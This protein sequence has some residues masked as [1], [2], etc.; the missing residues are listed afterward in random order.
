MSDEM[1]I[2]D[3]CKIKGIGPWSAEMFLMF[4][5]YDQIFYH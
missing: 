5:F 3:L 4:C 2:K 1:V